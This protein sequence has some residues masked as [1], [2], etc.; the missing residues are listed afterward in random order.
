MSR[1]GALGKELREKLLK[2]FDKIQELGPG[3]MAK[4]LPAPDD[5]PKK[6]RG[7]KRYRRMKEKYGQ[8]ELQ[9]YRN[10]LKFGEDGEEQ[11]GLEGAGLGMI[12]KSGIAKV[13][14]TA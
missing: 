10:R 13:K 5:K 9:K 1:N 2:R 3:K 7:G 8:T 14:M 6:R 11:Y 4:P 12:G